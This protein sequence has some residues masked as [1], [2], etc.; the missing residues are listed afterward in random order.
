MLVLMLLGWLPWLLLGGGA[1][2]L[3]LRAVRAFERRAAA[4]TE[5]VEL[6]ER[7]QALEDA[8]AGQGQEVQRLADGVQFAERLLAERSAADRGATSSAPAS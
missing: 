3:G 7:V 4:H 6:R 8:L 2:F 5:V 1:L